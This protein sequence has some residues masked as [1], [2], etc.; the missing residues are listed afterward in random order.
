MRIK[1][2][3]EILAYVPFNQIVIEFLNRKDTIVLTRQKPINIH[4]R[5]ICTKLMVYFA[6]GPAGMTPALE[7][8]PRIINCWIR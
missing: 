8:T 2:M 4:E 7:K 6:R 1:E 3:I 5:G